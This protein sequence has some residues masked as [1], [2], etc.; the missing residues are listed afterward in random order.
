MQIT[1]FDFINKLEFEKMLD[2]LSKYKIDDY[3]NKNFKGKQEILS[4]I[5]NELSKLNN[6]SR[7]KKEMLDLLT[8]YYKDSKEI[9]VIFYKEYDC[10]RISSIKRSYPV[11][12]L[13]M[14]QKE[15][16]IK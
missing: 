5:N 3:Y 13:E 8:E 7:Y 1:I 12:C 4:I 10:I 15:D 6:Y 11:F 9:E 2:K 14:I 16:R